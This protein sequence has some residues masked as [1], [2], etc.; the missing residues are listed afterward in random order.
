MEFNLPNIKN[1]LPNI[2][3]KIHGLTKSL[4]NGT[5]TACRDERIAAEALIDTNNRINKIK[6]NGNIRLNGKHANCTFDNYVTQSISFNKNKQALMDYNYKSN[7]LM[8]GGVGTGK[9][10]LAHAVIDKGLRNKNIKSCQYI[11][12][13]KLNNIKMEDKKLFNNSLYTDLLVIDEWG[14]YDNNH[15]SIV[16]F[17]LIDERYDM[18]KPTIIITNL[19]AEQTKA[20]ISEAMYSRISE[21]CLALQFVGD[22]YRLKKGV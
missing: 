13:Y 4:M 20:G 7:I 11:K 10:H 18:Q 8:C 5:C 15:K 16:E 6:A 1:N 22:N 2:D 3:C 14:S 9:T 19:T 12:S 21:D 17:E